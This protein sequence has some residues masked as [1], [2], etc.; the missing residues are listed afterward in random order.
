MAHSLT[1]LTFALFA[2][3]PC[4]AVLVGA[5]G[6]AASIG[7]GPDSGGDG[8]IQW[9]NEG[10]LPGVEIGVDGSSGG[11]GTTPCSGLACQIHSCPGGG[12]TTISGKVFDPAGKDPLYDI[13]VYVPNAKLDPLPSGASCDSCG[14]L[15]SGQPIAS[16]LTD[17]SGAFTIKNAPD[18][19]N[20][21]IV[22]QVG[23]WRMKFTIPH[24]AACTN[25]AQADG[26]LHLPKNRN[27]GADPSTTNIPN[28]AISTGGA[29]TLECLLRRIGV[30]SSEYGGGGSS[31]G[32][33]HIFQG[34]SNGKGSAPNTSPGGPSSPTA[35]WAT[36]ADLMAY[37]IVLLSC[38]GSETRSMNQQALHDYASAGGRVFASHFHYSWFNTGPY[39][40]ENLATWTTGSNSMGKIRS[41]IN[42]SF[43]KGKSLDE[44]LGVVG[45]LDSGGELPIDAAKHN[46]DVSASNTASTTWIS[47]DSAAS[48]PNATQYFSFNT[49]TNAT[50]NPDSGS[51][52]Y[53]G[54]VVF[55]DLHVGAASG[56]NPKQPIPD[57]CATGDLSA[58][59][60]AL[61]F[62][63]FD[64]SSCV[65][66]PT[67][68]PSDPIDSGP[69][70][71]H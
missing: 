2:L 64:L 48:P 68:T 23:K 27:D 28:I 39:G 37:D 26:S 35:L 46:A 59:E 14:S 53:C 10:G 44:W 49:P 41:T 50:I 65:E 52:N 21:P 67:A 33:I 9:N 22:V 61:E 43:P 5:C 6:S 40:S 38:E 12:S 62:M 7:D 56:D 47:S 57:E 4:S 20:I 71:I 25:N 3:V 16:A 51:P 11:D 19:D 24:V 34:S 66:P 36:S 55:S 8:S 63:L 1:R 54:R 60:K 13:V 70:A 45:A 30:D 18:G 69:I 29:D 15:F 58:Q 31:A 17:S 42:T 32:R